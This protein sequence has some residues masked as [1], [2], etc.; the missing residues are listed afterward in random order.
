MEPS[1]SNPQ[2][3]H[4]QRT[5]NRETRP[6]NFLLALVVWPTL[7]A[8]FTVRLPEM[9]I[10]AGFL[11]APME[12]T[13]GAALSGLTSAAMD[14]FCAGTVAAARAGRMR[15]S[16]LRSASQNVPHDSSTSIPTMK[17]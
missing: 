7:G 11:V 3:S 17:I 6:Q 13:P 15:A 5:G 4:I 14:M 10:S 2:S 12:P 1:K 9:V 8:G 16:S